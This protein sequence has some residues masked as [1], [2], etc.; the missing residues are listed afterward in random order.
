MTG[1]KPR[2]IG[3]SQRDAG[4]RFQAFRSPPADVAQTTSPEPTRQVTKM[5]RYA[6]P[7][8]AEIMQNQCSDAPVPVHFCPL[9]TLRDLRGE[10]IFSLAHRQPIKAPIEGEVSHGATETRRSRS[11]KSKRLSWSARFTIQ[12]HP[13]FLSV[14]PCLRERPLPESCRVCGVLGTHRNDG[15]WRQSSAT[16]SIPGAFRRLHAPYWTRHID[17]SVARPDAL[18]WTWS[19]G[20]GG[21]DRRI[22]RHALASGLDLFSCSTIPEN[23]EGNRTGG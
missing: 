1:R 11:K 21:T 4:Y 19:A 14:P 5:S 22:S 17:N 7:F 13:R 6:P 8:H 18:R 15:I 2:L 20:P 3:S 9:R 23:N 12:R 16:R 10:S